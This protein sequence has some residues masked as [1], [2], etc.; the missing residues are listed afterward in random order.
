MLGG[1]IAAFI[2]AQFIAVGGSSSHRVGLRDRVRVLHRGDV[3]PAAGPVRRQIVMQ[4]CS[5]NRADRPR[6]CWSLLPLVGALAAPGC[7]ELLSAPADPV[8]LWGFIYTSWSLMG[9]FGLTSLGH[10]AFIGHRRLRVVMLWNHFG[11]SPWI[12]VRSRVV[13]A[14]VVG[15]GDRLSVL[16]LPH[17]RP[18]LRARDAGARRGRA[19]VH[20]RPARPDRR[21]A[22]RAAERA[23]ATASRSARCSSR[24]TACCLYVA[25]ALWLVG[26]WV[27]WRVDRSMDRSRSRRPARTRTRRPRSAST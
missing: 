6:G 14:A 8:L 20:R 1:F 4:L 10:G 24:P 17:R 26:L 9:R 7:G 2:F 18:L 13:V 5:D 25:F 12:G 15:A 19:A 27:W 21:L 22:R 3:H 11:L 23:T 16:S